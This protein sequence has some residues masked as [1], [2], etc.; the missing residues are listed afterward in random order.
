MRGMSIFIVG[1][2]MT[3]AGCGSSDEKE[4]QTPPNAKSTPA[5]ATPSPVA[6]ALDGTW[7]T[8]A[9]SV[10]DMT[11]TLREQGLAKWV[12]RF[13]PRAPISEAPTSLILEI[14][15]GAW[16]LYGLPQGGEREKIDYDAQVKV[17]GNTVAASHEGDSNTY[18]W[19]VRDDVLA[20][21]WQKTTY[22]P[23]EGVPEEVFQRALY[24]TAKFRRTP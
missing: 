17:D 12:D 3:A 21:T 8:K 18:R 4:A 23:N 15:E 14:G 6:S 16:D 20:L 1:L 22:P 10:D 9:I 11:R 5:N 19:S 7:R 13:E 2:V 24:M